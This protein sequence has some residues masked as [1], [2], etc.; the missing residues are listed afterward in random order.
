MS[1]S[2]FRRESAVEFFKELV[3]GALAHQR[4]ATN[5]LTRQD[6]ARVY[7]NNRL[8]EFLNR[9]IVAKLRRGQIPETSRARALYLVNHI[10]MALV[11]LIVFVASFMA[12][13]FGIR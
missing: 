3:D 9:R 5:E 7:S 13:G 1:D 11:V 8:L 4:L 2:V 12:R 6:L 10:E